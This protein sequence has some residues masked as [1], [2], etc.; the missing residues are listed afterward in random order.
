M[1]SN[2]FEEAFG[3]FLDRREYDE[4]EAALF[5]IVRSAFLAGWQAAGG[6]LP[7]PQKVFSLIRRGGAG[8]RSQSAG[9]T[10]HP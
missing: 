4:A 7:V 8:E 6:E 3:A 10:D 2:D 5:G 1:M 9:E